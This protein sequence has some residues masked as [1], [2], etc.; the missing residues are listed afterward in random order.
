MMLMH[1]LHIF[2]LSFP[3]EPKA[4]NCLSFYFS[5]R[6]RNANIVYLLF[7]ETEY[8]YRLTRVIN[9]K[10]KKRDK[11]FYQ[12]CNSFC[13]NRNNNGWQNNGKSVQTVKDNSTEK[14][15]EKKALRRKMAT[16]NNERCNE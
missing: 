11:N 4:K 12:Y 1:S 16:K 15:E 13:E 8:S 7:V 14:E 3:I 6:N 9:C 2:H 5:Q 10:G